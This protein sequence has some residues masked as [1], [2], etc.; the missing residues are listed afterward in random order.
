MSR[1]MSA[2]VWFAGLLAVVLTLASVS[3]FGWAQQ[4]EATVLRG[5]M[6]ESPL[7]L[8]Q[9][10]GGCKNLNGYNACVAAEN[11]A[12]N[13]CKWASACSGQINRDCYN[14]FC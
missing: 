9:D 7:I 1:F 6:S 14:K 3:S 4:R 8:V 10:R 5:P 13:G 2:I 12:P 11:N